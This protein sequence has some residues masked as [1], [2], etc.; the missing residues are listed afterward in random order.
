[1]KDRKA[2][3]SEEKKQKTF[4]CWAPDCG[5]HPHQ[6]AKALWFFSAKRLPAPYR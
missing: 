2:F 5:R 4:F 1:M 3:F 6:G